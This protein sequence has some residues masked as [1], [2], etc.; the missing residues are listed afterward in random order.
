[1][2]K[3]DSDSYN[4]VEHIEF[5]NFDGLNGGDVGRLPTTISKVC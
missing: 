5:D 1:M 4:F 2:W 3:F